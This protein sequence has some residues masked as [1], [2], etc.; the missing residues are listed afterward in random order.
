MKTAVSVLAILLLFSQ[1]FS[2][3][4]GQG[5]YVK[6]K[7][8]E[9]TG[10][11]TVFI[12]LEGEIILNTWSLKIGEIQVETVTSGKVWGYHIN[13]DKVKKYDINIQQT[14]NMA[15]IKKSRENYSSGTIG[16]STFNVKHRH[17]FYLPESANISIHTND[18]D[19]SVNGNFKA[20]T[21][22]NKNGKND[23]KLNGSK[24]KSLECFTEDNKVIVNNLRKSREYRFNG[25]GS[26]IYDIRTGEGDIKIYLTHSGR[27]EEL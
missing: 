7:Q 24:I 2:Q 23:L 6:E 16:I 10:S 13:K 22:V 4:S 14:E 8:M 19:I 11:P 3:A 9:F 25:E 17:I 20:L 18:A 1:S 26:E 5:I 21:I 15:V 27:T 12:E